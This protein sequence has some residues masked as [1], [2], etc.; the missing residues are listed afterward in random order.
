[1]RRPRRANVVRSDDHRGGDRRRPGRNGRLMLEICERERGIAYDTKVA[2]DGG[3]SLVR[4]G[5]LQLAGNEFLKGKDNAVLAS[6]ADGSAA[7]LYRLDCIFDL[8]CLL[9]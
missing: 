9:A 1:M 2:V 4:A 7:V 5:L 8:L 6:Y 3:Y